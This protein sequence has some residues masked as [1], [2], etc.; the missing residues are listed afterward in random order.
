MVDIHPTQPNLVLFVS[1]TEFAD[2]VKPAKS[3]EIDLQWL[4]SLIQIV[5]ESCVKRV[6]GKELSP[7]AAIFIDA[8]STPEKIIPYLEGPTA[9]KVAFLYA[10]SE[11]LAHEQI[12]VI[13]TTI[14]TL[15]MDL[16]KFKSVFL[17]LG[18]F[19]VLPKVTDAELPDIIPLMK[20][21]K[22]LREAQIYC[23]YNR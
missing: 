16:Y 13:I 11:P 17:S 14:L 1:V 8:N 9:A 6:N 5:W 19:T 4:K 2:C 22:D 12:G 10:G 7:K 3:T 23:N 20:N 18:V 15:A 21:K